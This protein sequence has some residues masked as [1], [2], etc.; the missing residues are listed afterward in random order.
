MAK[1]N[2][3][4]LDK[5]SDIELLK[6][7]GDEVINIFDYPKSN[8]PKEELSSRAKIAISN[9]VNHLIICFESIPKD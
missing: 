1:L 8:L 2:K 6:F 3:K 4:F 9:F 5:I 7:Y